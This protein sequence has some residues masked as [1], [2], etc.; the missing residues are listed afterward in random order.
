[1]THTTLHKAGTYIPFSRSSVNDP[2]IIKTMYFSRKDVT[3]LPAV[4][5]TNSATQQQTIAVIIFHIKVIRALSTAWQ[6]LTCHFCFQLK[7]SF[8]PLLVNGVTM[9]RQS[10]SKVCSDPVYP[11]CENRFKKKVNAPLHISTLFSLKSKKET[12]NK[13]EQKK[14]QEVTW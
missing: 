13:W 4:L 7:R 1:M 12:K 11:G 8:F 14:C 2:G 6:G 9:S 10:L 5:E 3:G